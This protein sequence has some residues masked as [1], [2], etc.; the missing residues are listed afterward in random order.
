MNG[1]ALALALAFARPDSVA[2]L[3]FED[4]RAQVAAH[5]PV[6]R[7]ARLLESIADGNV[8][9]AR[10]S[11]DPV[12][13]AAWDRKDYAGK[14]YYDYL[15]AS[16]KVPTWV[17]V[18]LKLGFERTQGDYFASDRRT[19]GQGLLTAGVSIPLGQRLLTDERRT[20]LAQARAMREYAAGER[21]AL[22][23]K[24]MYTAAGV[25][26]SWFEAWRRVALAR[27]A[28]GLAEFRLEALRRRV[29]QG[30]AAAIDTLEAGLE[31]QRR[32]VQ[33]AE[34]G[35]AWRNASLVLEGMLW[36][37]RG[38]PGTLDPGAEPSTAGL[39][40][41]APS[42]DD[43][44]AWVQLAEQ[45]HPDL[46]K[47]AAKLRDATA[48][49]SLAA[50]RV[51]VPDAEVS[52]AGVGASRDGVPTPVGDAGDRKLGATLKVPLL[53]RKE[54]G[55]F[56]ATDA[57]AAQA[58]LDR[59]L[60]RRG[61]AIAIESSA[62]ALGAFSELVSL[63]EATVAQARALRDGEQRKFDAG[64]STLFLVNARERAVIDEELK[65]IALQAKLVSTGA[66]LAVALGQPTLS[67]R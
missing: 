27:E 22:V 23:N 19:P 46:Q 31:V 36:N 45:G 5:H 35:L 43:V 63:Q 41:R 33:Q 3:T 37:E 29:V 55:K 42:P 30:D 12:F 32:R 47:A 61:I 4:F 44:R 28:V 57:K 52:L 50:Q 38:E 11:F 24:L 7:Q 49:R 40:L 64:E 39:A 54:R 26:A 8:R 17:G 9:A 51:F 56:E 65:R 14:R 25:Y 60:V 34:A 62:N 15:D 58:G 53:F 2:P 48:E 1:V 20:A 16:L 67:D 59:A 21:A 18:D 13:S 6:A 66:E 10:G